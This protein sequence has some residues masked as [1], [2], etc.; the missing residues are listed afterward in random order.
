[1]SGVVK[2]DLKELTRLELWLENYR[3]N[4]DESI[5][6]KLILW[7]GRRQIHSVIQ[8][9]FFNTKN[10]LETGVRAA[11]KKKKKTRPCPQEKTL[12]DW[13]LDNYLL[14]LSL[15]CLIYTTGVKIVF[16]R[17]LCV[18]PRPS[19][20]SFMSFM[21]PLPKF[22]ILCCEMLLTF[23]SFMDYYIC[24]DCLTQVL[25]GKIFFSC[26]LHL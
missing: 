20:F 10:I 25:C 23:S 17:E 22:C 21:R 7:R 24:P 13:P 11:K 12:I 14:F 9:I 1:M 16:C 3:L 6:A 18:P 19:W 5:E 26:V 2:K 15:S 4:T 8:Q